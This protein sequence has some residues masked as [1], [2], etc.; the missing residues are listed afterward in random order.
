MSHL[1]WCCVLVSPLFNHTHV[2]VRPYN[3]YIHI[4][5]Y[6]V[7]V[8]LTNEAH[9]PPQEKIHGRN[10]FRPVLVGISREGVLRLDKK[11]KAVLKVWPLTTVRSYVATPS[12]FSLV[13]QLWMYTMFLHTLLLHVPLVLW[14]VEVGGFPRV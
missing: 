13:R 11:T 12:S 1:R 8:Q 10:K 3:T 4:R 2:H 7:L 5:T 6:T 14:N 9:L